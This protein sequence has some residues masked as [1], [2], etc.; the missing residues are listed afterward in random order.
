MCFIHVNPLTDVGPTWGTNVYTIGPVRRSAQAL[1]S[2]RRMRF[3]SGSVVHVWARRDRT[4]ENRVQ[5]AT[6]AA[7]LS[8]EGKEDAAVAPS[9]V[10]YV[11]SEHKY[12]WEIL[13]V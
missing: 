4:G 2:R 1:E 10:V 11:N 7:G 12:Q 3:G 5:L 6:L 13:L 8:K 9:I